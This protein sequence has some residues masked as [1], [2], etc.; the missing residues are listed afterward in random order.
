MEVSAARAGNAV[1]VTI[2]L[3]L[4]GP[5]NSIEKPIA[6]QHVVLSEHDRFA[7]KDSVHVQHVFLHITN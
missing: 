2:T 3:F 1:P 7:V 5:S 4:L 6:C